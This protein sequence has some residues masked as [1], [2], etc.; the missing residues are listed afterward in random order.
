MLLSLF[1]GDMAGFDELA[2]QRLIARDL[3]Y[4]SSTI[5]I[6]PAV[7]YL[8]EVSDVAIQPRGRECGAHARV[9][10]VIKA[11]VVDVEIGKLN[12]EPKPLGKRE[13]GIGRVG[14]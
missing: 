2:H 11:F 7:A 10:G 1:L 5:Y 14:L 4:D 3:L 8:S 13:P 12:G 6:G 9:F